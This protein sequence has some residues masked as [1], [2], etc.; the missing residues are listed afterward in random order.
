MGSI[1]RSLDAS[2]LAYLDAMVGQ[3]MLDWPDVPDQLDTR[4]LPHDVHVAVMTY[5]ADLFS[6]YAGSLD[7]D[8]YF[9]PERQGTYFGSF[10]L[11][12]ARA[13]SD[14]SHVIDSNLTAD[15]GRA[16]WRP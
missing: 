14:P 1:L 4:S 3:G 9:C 5:A 10:Y 7:A 8:V 15:M 6:W 16:F 11:K 12:D 2:Q 13:M